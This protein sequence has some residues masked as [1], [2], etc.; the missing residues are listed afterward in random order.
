MINNMKTKNVQTVLKIH[1]YERF[2]EVLKHEKIPLKEGVREAILTWTR[3]KV[4]FN[5]EDPFFATKNQFSGKKDM[6]KGH[7]EIYEGNE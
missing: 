1:E 3:Q 6:A 5:R 4:G 7:D 2:R